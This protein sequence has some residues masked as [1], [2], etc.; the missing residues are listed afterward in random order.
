[1]RRDP[2]LAE[3]A[4]EKLGE[5]LRYALRIQREGRDE[6]SLGEEWAFVSTYLDLER[7][8]L[9]ERLRVS[10][11]AEDGV[12][13]S[14]LPSLALQTLVENAVRHAVAPHVEGGRIDISA[15]RADGRLR[16]EVVDDG[17]PRPVAAPGEG[18][19]VGLPLLGERLAALYDGRARLALEAGPTG[20]R[21]LL[22]VP[23]DSDEERPLATVDP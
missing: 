16:I 20:T 18:R 23:L 21:A 4:L 3:E 10:F 2:A 15:R 6:V 9:G 8:R 13:A 1:M 5:L 14:R 19:G 12:L 11:T 22:E 17:P 7:L